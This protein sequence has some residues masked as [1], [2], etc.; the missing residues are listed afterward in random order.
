MRAAASVA[1]TEI[2]CLLF[3]GC[4]RVIEGGKVPSPLMESTSSQSTTQASLSSSTLLWSV[5]D[6]MGGLLVIV[7]LLYAVIVLA[8]IHFLCAWCVQV[9]CLFMRSATHCASATQC[10]PNQATTHVRPVCN[11]CATPCQTHDSFFTSH[12]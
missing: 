3:Y 10:N 8:I 1:A 5:M 7:C 12:N 2:A 11:P 6:K 4:F 9:C